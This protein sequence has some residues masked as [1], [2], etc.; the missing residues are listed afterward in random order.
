MMSGAAVPGGS[1]CRRSQPGEPKRT[2][3]EKRGARAGNRKYGVLRWVGIPRQ[4]IA[5]AAF[6]QALSGI[7]LLHKAASPHPSGM[8]RRRTAIQKTRKRYALTQQVNIRK[9]EISQ[10]TRDGVR[11]RDVNRV[12]LFLRQA[13]RA[14]ADT[15]HAYQ[16]GRAGDAS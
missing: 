11:S 14:E 1:A 13:G 3:A 16:A 12:L 10:H 5:A 15:C 4:I 7:S 8:S 6:R 9:H 2:A